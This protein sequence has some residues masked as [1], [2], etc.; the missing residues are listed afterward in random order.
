MYGRDVSYHAEKPACYIRHAQLTPALKPAFLPQRLFQPNVLAP[1]FSLSLL[2]SLLEEEKDWKEKV[3]H[4]L[5][6][7]YDKYMNRTILKIPLMSFFTL[8]SDDS[9]KHVLINVML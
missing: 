1:K 9:I 3:K 6:N 5:V 2:K 4:V 8:L 7:K